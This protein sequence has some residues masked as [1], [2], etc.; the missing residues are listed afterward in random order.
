MVK[1]DF[2]T[3]WRFDSIEI[4]KILEKHSDSDHI[5]TMGEIVNKTRNKP[6]RRTVYKMIQSLISYGYDISTYADNGKGYYL[7]R[8]INES[9]INLLTNA[10]YSFPFISSEHTNELVN[11]LRNLLSK[12][13]QKNYTH[14]TLSDKDKK[15]DNQEVF[16]NI[17]IIDEAIE[18]NRKISFYY[19]KYGFDKKLQLHRNEPFVMNP[20]RVVYSN[21]HCYLVC[22]LCGHNGTAMYRIDRIKD[23]EI[24]KEKRDKQPPDESE[25]KNTLYG[26]AG[27]QELIVLK[28][29]NKVLTEIIDQFGT[30]ITLIPHQDETFTAYIRISPKGIVYWALQFMKHVEVVEPLWLRK[31]ITDT[32]NNSKYLYK[33][34]AKWIKKNLTK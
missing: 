20:Y 30:D 16:N 18:K 34:E 4:L 1:D 2:G 32:I 3:K 11:K 13:K 14:L 22:N 10:V 23:V 24:L 26:F 29:D 31:E 9:E 19:Y 21:Q 5:L 8:D 27:E 12:S 17:E 7:I 15:V 25:Y 6:D 28:C 33:G